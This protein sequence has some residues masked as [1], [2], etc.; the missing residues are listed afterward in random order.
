MRH[1]DELTAYLRRRFTRDDPDWARGGGTWPVRV[2]RR[3]AEMDVACRQV[4]VG[5]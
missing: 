3:L 2:P 5:C 4:D 1:P